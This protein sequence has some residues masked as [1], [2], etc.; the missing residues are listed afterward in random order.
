MA[1]SK[2]TGVSWRSDIQQYKATL[3]FK[4]AKVECGYSNTERGAAILRDKKILVLGADQKKL[5]VLK[6]IKK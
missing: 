5:Q 2:Y 1:S 3:S 6:P 4:G